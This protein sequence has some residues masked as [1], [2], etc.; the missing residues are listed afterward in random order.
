MAFTL[1]DII[2]CNSRLENFIF[3]FFECPEICVNRSLV[4]ELYHSLQRNIIQ[5]QSVSKRALQI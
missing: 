1:V 3:S 5:I 4:V 2:I